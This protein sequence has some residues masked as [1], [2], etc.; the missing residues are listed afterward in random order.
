MNHTY[1]LLLSLYIAGPTTI[2][3]LYKTAVG[4]A[5]A[6]GHAEWRRNPRHLVITPDGIDWLYDHATVEFVEFVTDETPTP[7]YKAGDRTASSLTELLGVVEDPVTL[8]PPLRS[9]VQH[10]AIRALS[11]LPPNLPRGFGHARNRKWLT[12]EGAVT[13]AGLE[14]FKRNPIV[15]VEIASLIL[16]CAVTPAW[17]HAGVVY[18]SL[19]DIVK[20]LR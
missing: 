9:N 15:T 11:D 5:V 8:V 12:E 2:A 3:G 18:D 4:H 10:A 1:N 13:P 20:D 7:V 14:A 16:N 6:A 19:T 17:K